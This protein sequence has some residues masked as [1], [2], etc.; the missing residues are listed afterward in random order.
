MIYLISHSVLREI[1]EHVFTYNV[2]VMIINVLG[3]YLY[4]S[5]VYKNKI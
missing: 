1:Y 4:A 3:A 2:I 5:V